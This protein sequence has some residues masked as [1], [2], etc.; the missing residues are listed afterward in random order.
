L[1][2][3]LRTLTTKSKLTPIPATADIRGRILRVEAVAVSPV[4]V[5]SAAASLLEEIKTGINTKKPTIRPNI[6]IMAPSLFKF[7]KLLAILNYIFIVFT[8]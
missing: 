1:F 4:N 5:A 3:L 6:I 2:H 7:I 8:I